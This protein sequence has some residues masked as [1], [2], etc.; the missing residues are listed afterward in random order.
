MMCIAFIAL[1]L[2]NNLFYAL[3]VA[4]LL[5][6]SKYSKC[7]KAIKYSESRVKTLQRFFN[8]ASRYMAL[9]VLLLRINFSVENAEKLRYVHT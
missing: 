4:E 1:F 7:L 3:R 8:P 9:K 5:A 2:K 6:Y